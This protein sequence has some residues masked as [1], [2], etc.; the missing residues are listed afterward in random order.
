MNMEE[1]IL[2]IVPFGK[3]KGKSVLELLSDE[4]YIEWLKQQT[5]FPNHKQIY[6]IVVHQSITTTNNSKTPE[7]N[8]L[9]NLFLDT[10][11]QQKLLSKMFMFDSIDKINDLLS[12]ENITRCFGVK[13]LSNLT[14]NLDKSRIIFEDKYNWDL[15]LYN[16]DRQSV[17]I[18]SKLETELKDK[19]I[20]KEQYD[21]EQ[22]EIYK[23][24]IQQHEETI[25]IREHIDKEQTEMFETKM[26]NY[27]E[28]KD[29]N[30]M[31]VNSY[32]CELEEYFKIRSGYEMKKI[33][34]LCQELKLRSFYSNEKQLFEFLDKDKELNLSEKETYKKIISEKMKNIMKEWENDN[35]SLKPKKIDKL[36][37]PEPF[38][39][40]KSI[41][42]GYGFEKKYKDLFKDL[43]KNNT[44]LVQTI[45]EVKNYD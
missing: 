12:D 44:N 25:R 24:T 6:N 19:E 28:Q 2:P 42:V 38:D 31:E 34:E 3:Y 37:I 8:K 21:I 26:K 5:F 22:Q 14:N 40:N 20:Y 23:K 36:T 33:K 10:S 29:K 15:V 9:Q 4:K 13:K 41:Y 45:L 11:N 16:K 43:L 30:Q 27:I 18:T 7:H 35:S 39:K 17:E 1:Q 32:E